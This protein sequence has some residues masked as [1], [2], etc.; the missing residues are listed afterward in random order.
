MYKTYPKLITFYLVFFSLLITQPALAK[1]IGAKEIVAKEIIASEGLQNK[2]VKTKS[3]NQDGFIYDIQKIDPKLLADDVEKL[4][5]DLIRH[6]YE[7]V[8]L[9][10]QK[11]L[12]AGDVIITII[13]PG[14]LLYAGYRKHELEQAKDTLLTVSDD[15]SE[16]SNDLVALQ[17]HD[18]ANPIILAQL[19]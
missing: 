2:I 7:L 13:M 18:T 14:G 11:E 3:V 9:V 15:I 8:K 6:Q 12:D 17:G 16:F 1:E 4:R 10:D 19:P 5:S